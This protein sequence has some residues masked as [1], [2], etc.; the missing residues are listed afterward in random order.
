MKVVVLTVEA[1][2]Q[3]ALCRKLDAH[4]ELVGIVLSRNIVKRRF[5]HRLWIFRNRVEGRLVRSPF[6]TV[7]RELQHRYR[8]HV[9]TF[10]DVPVVRVRNVNDPTT[11][12]FLRQV[13]PDLVV[14]SGTN[15]VD[16]RIIEWSS[17]CR[18]IINLHT[19]LSPYMKG[20]PDCTNWCL[21]ERA[22]HVIG[23]TVLWL[24]AGIDSGPILST[25]RT[26]LTGRE[27][28]FE[29][30]W[31]VMEH[32]HDLC[33]RAVRALAAGRPV[34]RIAQ[35]RIAEGRT[36]SSLEW[37]RAAIRR[38]WANFT[39]L[40]NPDSLSGDGSGH[41]SARLTLYPLDPPGGSSPRSVP[42]PGVPAG[43]PTVSVVRG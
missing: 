17:G 38:A 24:D 33:V 14:V 35:D 25:E 5:W 4:C 1:P 36:C 31:K 8:T 7:W 29:L 42:A 21:V 10:P 30:H 18:G 15:L 19:G 43:L 13:A 40:Y 32:A 9:P 34:P 6:V 39:T 37:G 3:A 27:T 11:L 22:F 23:S 16:R 20:G 26:P 2:N 12:R 28:L 41:P